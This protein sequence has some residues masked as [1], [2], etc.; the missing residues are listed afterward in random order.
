ML[1]INF[2]KPNN[3]LNFAGMEFMDYPS[4]ELFPKLTK[5]F[6]EKVLPAGE[7][8]F[9]LD[10]L[11]ITKES[12]KGIQELIFT[13]TG[14][15][16]L[17]LSSDTIGNMGVDVAYLTPHN[18]L[19]TNI[20]DQIMDKSD[21]TIARAMKI[22][23]T[24]ILKGWVD[25]STGRVGG[26]FSKIEF[27][28]EVNPWVDE[29]LR[30]KIL[31]RYKCSM[32]EALAVTVIH[33]LGHIFTGLLYITRVAFDAI[34]PM[35]AIKL[36]SQKSTYGRERAVIVNDAL[37]GLE[38]PPTAKVEDLDKMDSDG[39]AL[40]FSKAISN[41]DMHRTLSL[42]TADRGSELLADL[43]AVR[44]GCPKTMIIAV[45]S[46]DAGMP[47]EM[48]ISGLAFTVALCSTGSVI[49]T[50]FG[51]VLLA[52]TLLL[53]LGSTLIPNSAYDS[54]YR[55]MK[56]ILRDVIIR[57][58][59]DK[60]IDKRQKVKMLAEAKEMEKIVEEAKNLLEGTA[61]QRVMGYILSGTDYRA[62]EFENYTDELVGHTLSLYKETF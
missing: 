50:G 56:A 5:F 31:T 16:V 47:K 14:I 54:P 24:D 35:T 21:T 8:D 60:V 26:D 55:R 51:G 40:Y 20:Y 61:I 32:A 18:L 59:E 7:D 34:L 62:Q 38:I 11:E 58:N 29:I 19:N 41:R 27:S 42:G 1:G 52:G 25:T 39:L 36:I 48:L 44:M 49:L 15:N 13:A 3:P 43:Y 2:L 28:M 6:Q 4:S 22:I 37:K 10:K 53:K 30:R 12:V 57:L 46:L 23:K 33:E 45:S 17:M 9:N